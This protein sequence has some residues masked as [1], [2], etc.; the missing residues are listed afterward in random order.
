MQA[1]WCAFV[2]VLLLTAGL[3]QAT[4]PSPN[5]R[6][7]TTVPPDSL[8][9]CYELK[10][11]RWWPW[12]FGEGA[13]FVTPPKRLRLLAVRGTR[14]FEHDELL[15]RDIPTLELAP[16]S[17]ESSFWRIESQDRITLIWTNGFNGVT[18]SV[19][20]H[21]N[22]LRGWSHPHFDFP[23]FVPRSAHVT[24]HRIACPSQ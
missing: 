15:I 19:E 5:S 17:R 21:G 1:P 4:K 8:A 9:G 16:G 20:K 13:T 2:T 23:T 18:L 12:G 24:A 14:G 22:E 10:V 7:K 3:P 11:G 6:N